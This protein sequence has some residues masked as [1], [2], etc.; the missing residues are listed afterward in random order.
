M[1]THFFMGILALLSGAVLGLNLSE[2]TLLFFVIFFVIILELFNTGL[3]NLVDMVS[4]NIQAKAKVAKDVSA[5]A[6]LCAAVLS[7]IV[8]TLLFVPKII[9]ILA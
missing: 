4:P 8:G 1:Q 2:W 6:V 5:A 9:E 3:E 7:I